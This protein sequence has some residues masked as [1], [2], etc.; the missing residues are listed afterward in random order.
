[1]RAYKDHDTSP[2]LTDNAD[3]PDPPDN[4]QNMS[5]AARASGKRPPSSA[6]TAKRATVLLDFDG[7]ILRHPRASELIRDRCE[8]YVSNMTSCHPTSSAAR[9][10]N[11]ALYTTYGHTMYG[12][13][14]LGYSASLQRFNSYVYGAINYD[15]LMADSA[16]LHKAIMADLYD[17]SKHHD[18]YIFSNAPVTW[19]LEIMGRL[20]TLLPPSCLSSVD[21][22]PVPEH[23]PRNAHYV[24]PGLHIL[25]TPYL[26]PDV[27][28]YEDI[29]RM[30]L[31]VDQKGGVLSNNNKKD[32]KFYFVEDSFVNLAPVVSRPRWRSMLLADSYFALPNGVT[33]VD[34]IARVK[35]HIAYV[36]SS[37]STNHG[38]MV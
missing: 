9:Q 30:F 22:R 38:N 15:A 19:C 37:H 13:Y 32:D 3:T 33:L 25:Q 21:E 24:A 26:K 20:V 36:N 7:V 28:A 14:R 18:T 31:H 10:L 2:P 29:E 27:R 11:R 1:M 17:L 8:R 35:T 6:S 23:L 5:F 16:E 34:S 12:L 4:P